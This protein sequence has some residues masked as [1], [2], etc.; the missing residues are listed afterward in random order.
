MKCNHEWQEGL[1]GDLICL[2][3]DK[4][5]TL[6]AKEDWEKRHGSSTDTGRDRSSAETAD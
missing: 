1:A 6:V 5:K 2:W 4:C 3:C